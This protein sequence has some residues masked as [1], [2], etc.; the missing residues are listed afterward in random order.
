[1]NKD[2][3]IHLSALLAFGI[4]IGLGGWLL[5]YGA[6][7]TP[8][9]IYDDSYITL[10]NAL[11]LKGE[12]SHFA[13]PALT[14]ATSIAHAVLVAAIA[15][16]APPE[17]ALGLSNALAT[18][19]YVVGL[20]RLAE[21]FDQSRLVSIGIALIGTSTAYTSLHLYNGL[22]TS[23][24]LAAT[25]WSLVFLAANKP[26]PLALTCAILPWIRP[27]L[28]AWSGVALSLNFY[29]NRN[30]HDFFRT[31]GQALILF[32]LATSPFLILCWANTGSPIP[33]TMSAKKYFFAESCAPDDWRNDVTIR[34]IV[35][36]TSGLWLTALG[37]IALPFSNVGRGVLIFITIFIAA[38]WLNFP[39]ALSHYDHRYLHVLVPFLLFST[40]HILK[41]IAIKRR[42]PA[43]A[44]I[45]VLLTP[46]LAINVPNVQLRAAEGRSFSE[47]HLAPVTYWT[48]EHTPLNS[49]ILV[50]DAGYVGY[51]AKRK[52]V[53]FVGLKTPAAITAHQ[54]YTH[55]S[56][57]EKR[58]LAIAEI[59]QATASDYL[60]ILNEW[61]RIF[62]I[63]EGL[64]KQDIRIKE[65]FHDQFGY[66]IYRIMH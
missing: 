38:Y 29:T 52:L 50:H 11:A 63:T 10:A 37:F 12:G 30:S 20:V 58:A 65:V 62:N 4:L 40:L 3:P 34:S 27:E 42:L 8:W 61:N 66:N 9:F 33:L 25:T 5:N 53:D 59:I 6:T 64:S 49:T 7:M 28:V 14:G 56:C 24:A 19:V 54:T 47:K 22:E 13:S 44:L 16:V 31:M 18:V 60:V 36:W 57:G 55:P 41:R 45:V 2:G 1:M 51:A 35:G 39:G 21:K 26:H 23:L 43:I 48:N 17:F 32:T 46:N 15:S